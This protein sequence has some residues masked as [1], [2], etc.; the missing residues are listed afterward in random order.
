VHRV[1][2]TIAS[3]LLPSTDRQPPIS[4]PLQT[5]RQPDVLPPLPTL[6]TTTLTSLYHVASGHLLV[7]VLKGEGPSTGN[8]FSGKR[9]R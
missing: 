4:F 3:L 5:T 2:N 9:H 6:T 7:N 1:L 8:H